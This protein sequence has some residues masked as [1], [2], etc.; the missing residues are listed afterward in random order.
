MTRLCVAVVVL[1]AVIALSG[2][3]E[4]VGQKMVDVP[5]FTAVDQN[6]RQVGKQDLAGRPWIAAFIFTRCA[7]PCPMMTAKMKQ[8]QEALGD[9]RVMLVSFTVDPSHDSPAVLKQYM[10]ERSA[11]EGNWLMLNA[12]SEQEVFALART[13]NIGIS[14]AGEE[15]IHGTHFILVDGEGGI[16]GYYS[17]T[18]D[19]GWQKAVRNARRLSR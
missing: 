14:R 2:C 4:A 9:A 15:I 7:G 13:M 6:G 18:D 1:A 12:G 3:D 5:E 16:R 11:D 17:G 19:E 8:M 10:R